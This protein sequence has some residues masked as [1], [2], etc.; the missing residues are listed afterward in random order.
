MI[1]RNSPSI[2][3]SSPSAASYVFNQEVVAAYNCTDGGSG[4]ATCTA[5]VAKGVNLNTRRAG[6]ASFTVTA[7]DVAGNSSSASV[8][9]TVGYG[10]C[11]LYDPTKPAKSGSTIPIKL[12]LCDAKSNDVSAADVVVHATNLIQTSTNRALTVVNVGSA[13]SD[14]DFRY[15]PGLG[16]AGGYILNLKTTGLTTGT[17]GLVFVAGNDPTTHVAYF[18]VR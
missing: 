14:G 5:S 10:L 3:I 17:Y 12:Q 16:L 9:Y 15:D 4:V 2:T 1:D 13:Y 8:N 6:T 18:Q 11:L 7:S